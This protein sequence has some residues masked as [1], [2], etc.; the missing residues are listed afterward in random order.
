MADIP[1]SGLPATRCRM[2]RF[3]QSILDY[4]LVDTDCFPRAPRVQVL[5][6]DV[7]DYYLVH[8]V[9]KRRARCTAPASM[10]TRHKYRTN[11]LQDLHV[12]EAYS[13]HIASQFIVLMQQQM[14]EQTQ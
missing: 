11:K 14:I 13:A 8:F 1:A 3:E 9:M 10:H 4:F 6:A 12:R 2:S 7:Y 5:K